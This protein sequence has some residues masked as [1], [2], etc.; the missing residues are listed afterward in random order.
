M[1][2]GIANQDFAQAEKAFGVDVERFSP[3]LTM[4]CWIN[5]VSEPDVK[6]IAGV[7]MDE[8][9]EPSSLADSPDHA[10]THTDNLDST[11]QPST[12]LP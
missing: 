12:D 9:D 4:R 2:L 7:P 10:T 8:A 11:E 1:S 5:P 6:F 3:L